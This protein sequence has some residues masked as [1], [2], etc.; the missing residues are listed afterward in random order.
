MPADK[1][2]FPGLTAKES[3]ETPAP[4]GLPPTG[5]GGAGR[6]A[7]EVPGFKLFQVDEFRGHHPGLFT[8]PHQFRGLEEASR[9]FG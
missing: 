2:V 9:G 5:G 8:N 7:S 4:G 1:S 3:H 6:L